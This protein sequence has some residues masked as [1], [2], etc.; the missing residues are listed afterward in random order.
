MFN[1]ISYLELWWPLCSVE[2]NHL[3]DFG[4]RH[5]E[6]HFCEIILN[7]DEW[8]RKD[9]VL[10]YFLSRVLTAFLFCVPFVQFS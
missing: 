10:R 6:E 1:Q 5:H 7:L 3:W 9:V 8:L 2:Q 4:I